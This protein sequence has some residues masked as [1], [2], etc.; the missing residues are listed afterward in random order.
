M[1]AKIAA[2][3]SFDFSHDEVKGGRARS[4]AASASTTVIG[5]RPAAADAHVPARF[6]QKQV[7]DTLEGRSSFRELSCP[8]HRHGLALQTRQGVWCGVQA[9]LGLPD[10]HRP[11]TFNLE[12]RFRT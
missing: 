3:S 8:M 12:R 11:R 7:A 10:L 2:A 6:G 9:A 4:A 1:H 5:V